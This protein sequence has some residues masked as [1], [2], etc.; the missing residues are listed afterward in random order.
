MWLA[1]C[2][3]L[4]APGAPRSV[5]GDKSSPFCRELVARRGQAAAESLRD[6]AGVA[7]LWQ[8]WVLMVAQPGPLWSGSR[9]A[10]WVCTRL[11]G[12]VV[13]L[14]AVVITVLCVF[15]SEVNFLGK[16]TPFEHIF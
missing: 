13:E 6:W 16:L 1:D 12:G 5:T 4:L 7:A 14:C 3:P 9:G 10:T 8:A 15:S 2:P 11:G